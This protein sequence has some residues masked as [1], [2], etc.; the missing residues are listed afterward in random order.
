MDQCFKGQSYK[1]Y[2]RNVAFTLG[3]FHIEQMGVL[4]I[5]EFRFQHFTL[6]DIPVTKVG[7]DALMAVTRNSTISC[8]VTPCTTKEV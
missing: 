4:Q 7:V 8:N 5:D 2:N 3:A 1:A 6:S